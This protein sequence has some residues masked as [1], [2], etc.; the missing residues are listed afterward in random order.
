M[1][2]GEREGEREEDDTMI[3]DNIWLCVGREEGRGI[4]CS[5]GGCCGGDGGGR[6]MAE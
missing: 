4:G 1:E 3:S 6:E 5:G 2:V